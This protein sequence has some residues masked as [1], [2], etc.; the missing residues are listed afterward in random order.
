LQYLAQQ[1]FAIR[2]NDASGGNFKS[3]LQLWAADDAN[4]SRKTTFTC[5]EIQN[6]LLELM[7]RTIINDICNK[8]NNKSAK[9]GLV[10]DGMQDIQG[11]EQESVCIHHVMDSFSVQEDFIGLYQ[12]PSTTGVSLS[13]MSQDVLIR[14]QL[15][16]ENLRAQ[17]YDGASNMSGKF[18]GCQ[19]EIKKLQPLALCIHC[20]I[21]VTQLVTS[22]AVQS[23]PFIRDTLD[24]V[25]ELGTLYSQSRKLKHFYLNIHVDDAD[26]PCPTWLKPICPTC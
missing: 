19:A 8:V 6:E 16:I 3:L 23:A 10:V 15:L 21:H 2:G 4:L 11:N 18:K 24:H 20:G 12:V 22:K 13:R 9:F 25:Q 7:S 26:I 14:C 5:G 17:T 1:G